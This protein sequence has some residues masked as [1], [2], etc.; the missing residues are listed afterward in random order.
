LHARGREE[1]HDSEGL[2]VAAGPPAAADLRSVSQ[3]RIVTV[4]SA[5]AAT[6]V[7]GP[8]QRL[9]TRTPPTVTVT[10][11]VTPLRERRGCYV[12]GPPLHWHLHAAI[13]ACRG[14]RPSRWATI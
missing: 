8:G 7:T 6:T 12:T 11:T 3:V 10:V 9:V 2:Q 13:A 4:L 1:F 14:R 5:A